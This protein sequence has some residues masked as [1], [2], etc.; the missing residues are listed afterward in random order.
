MFTGLLGMRLAGEDG[1]RARFAMAGGGSG[2]VVDVAA[3]VRDRGLQA[4][5]TVHHVAFRAP[6]LATM[7]RWRGELVDRGLQVTEILDR[8]YFK[9]I[10]FREPGGVLLEIATDRPVSPSTSRCWSWAGAEAAAVAGAQPRADRAALPPLE[11]T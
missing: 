3:G 6:D 8:Q 5:G 2:A 7:T 11:V 10:Y 1:D 9:S 4:G